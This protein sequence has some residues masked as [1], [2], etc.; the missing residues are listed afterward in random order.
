MNNIVVRTAKK[1]YVCDCCGR[2][3][4]AKT[5]YLDKVIMHDGEKV[6]HERYHDECPKESPI[7]RMM[8]LI[9][10][11]ES[12]E[13]PASDDGLKYIIAGAYWDFE[14]NDWAVRLYDWAKTLQTK[15]WKDCKK[16][17]LADGRTLA[18]L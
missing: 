18:E 17:R 11:D 5:E 7:V 13:L 1:D 15:S 2:L 16:F 8:E 10:E 3:I 4:K 6:R 14:S 12:H 9:A